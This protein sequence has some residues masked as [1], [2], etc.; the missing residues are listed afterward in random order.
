L[1][2]AK[3]QNRETKPV[4]FLSIEFPRFNENKKKHWKY[5]FLRNLR[6]LMNFTGFGAGKS[7]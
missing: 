2:I 1:V 3:C 4:T 5:F 6:K 7:L